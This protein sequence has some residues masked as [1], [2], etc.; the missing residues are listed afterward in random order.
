MKIPKKYY[1]DKSVL[2]LLSANAGLFILSVATV[3][4]NVDSQLSGTSIVSYRSTR[5]IQVSGPTSELYQFAI[6]AAIVTIF[7]LFLSMKLYSYRRHLAIS[8]LGLNVI[9]LVLCMV[10]FNALTRTL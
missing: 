1:H 3:L 9:S 2:A 10:V 8:I 4:F 5:S 6:F 7:S